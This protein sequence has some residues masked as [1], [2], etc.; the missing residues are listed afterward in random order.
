MR[1]T[2]D[3]TEKE[4]LDISEYQQKNSIKNFSET[5]RTLV[6]VALSEQG[7]SDENFALLADAIMKMDKKLDLMMI[8]IAPKSAGEV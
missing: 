8:N 2:I 4:L 3:L 5:I 6:R 7:L 1:K